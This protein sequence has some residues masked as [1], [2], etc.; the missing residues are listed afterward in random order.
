MD[1]NTH[2]DD[3]LSPSSFLTDS[4]LEGRAEYEVKT[5]DKEADDAFLTL[6]DALKTY[7][8]ILDKPK[9]EALKEMT[10]EELPQTELSVYCQ[11]CRAI[12]EPGA[13]KT[14]RGKPRQVCGICGSKKIARGREESLKKFYH[15][16]KKA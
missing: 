14:Q 6:D 11:D 12:V 2:T 9:S 5:K 16:E 1:K 8:H 3:R 10:E 4:Q 13:G 7:W 15:L